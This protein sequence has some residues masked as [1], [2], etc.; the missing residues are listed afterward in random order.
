MNRYNQGLISDFFEF[1][2]R[3][4]AVALFHD[5]LH[6]FLLELSSIVRDNPEAESSMLEDLVINLAKLNT[7]RLQIDDETEAEDVKAQEESVLH[8]LRSAINTT[9]MQKLIKDRLMDYLTFN[10]YHLPMYA[11]AGSW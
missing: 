8:D 4:W 11:R 3:P 1:F 10:S 2:R 7:T 5:R 6:P 9:K